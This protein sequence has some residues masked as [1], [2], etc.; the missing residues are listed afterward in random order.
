MKTYL[1]TTLLIGLGEIEAV[2]ARRGDTAEIA[3]V[4]DGMAR[5]DRRERLRLL[6]K[7]VAS[8]TRQM[9]LLLDAED[10]KGG[11]RSREDAKSPTGEN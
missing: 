6:G 3:E 7:T 10:G 5:H 8:A 1:K 11:T 9:M 4:L 2:L